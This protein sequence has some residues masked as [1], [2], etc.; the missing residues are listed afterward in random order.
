MVW[1]DEINPGVC[2]YVSQVYSSRVGQDSTYED[3]LYLVEDMKQIYGKV[4]NLT[5]DQVE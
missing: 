5:K 3:V 1:A 4:F 2:G